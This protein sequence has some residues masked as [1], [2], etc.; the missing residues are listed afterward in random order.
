MCSLAEEK[1]RAEDAA[2]LKTSK[3]IGKGQCGTIYALTATAPTAVI[4]LPNASNKETELHNDDRIHLR[5]QKA[6]AT[7]PSSRWDINVPGLLG[8]VSSNTEPFWANHAG[9]L[10][11]NY[12]LLSER[13]FP[14]QAPVR[15]AIVDRLCPK[16]IT[17]NKKDFL[18]KAEN[19]DCLVRLYLGGRT[20]SRTRMD[21]SSIRL[22]NFPLHVDEM[23][24]LKLDTGGY[25]KVI[26]RALAILHWRAGV[27]ANDVEFVFGCAPQVRGPSQH[28]LPEEL[29]NTSMENAHMD[30]AE[31][32]LQTDIT[33][34]SVR[35]WLLDFNQCERFCDDEEGLK[36][37]VNG[38]W[39]NDPYYPRP[40]STNKHDKQLWKT[41]AQQYLEVSGELTDSKMPGRF[42]KGVEAEGKK[43]ASSGS[44]FS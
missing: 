19:E 41:F 26:A 2:N 35:I 37:L 30:L 42:I 34:G 28:R 5:V 1:Q 10:V 11:P 23:E 22:R 12:G 40:N 25:A 17:G 7:V 21:A 8:W 32:L 6:F 43:R 14:L 18:N 20:V 9:S 33:T 27:D 38:Y 36:Q 24:S 29:E 4:K 31:R 16:S 44:V 39:W 13:I 15:E 3:E